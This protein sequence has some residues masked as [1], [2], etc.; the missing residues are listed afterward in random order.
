MD[1]LTLVSNVALWV[2]SL[3]NLA[4][5]FVLARQIGVLHGRLPPVGAR[6]NPGGP[7]LGET[8]EPVAGAAI[9]GSVSPVVL[10]P[11]ERRQ[12]IVFITTD[13][14]AC[15]DLMPAVRSL[16]HS[17]SPTL[18]TTIVSLSGTIDDN[19]PFVKAHRLHRVRYVLAPEARSAYAIPVTPFAVLV[20]EHGS[21][22][23]K[24][25]VNRM[26]QLESLLEWEPHDMGEPHEH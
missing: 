4:A 13:C 3:V 2:L 26:E 14:S 19:R 7:P 18:T 8:L 10:P 16:A 23:S 24:A 15:A 1:G 22:V 5:V 20:D 21:V 6:G 25:L 9:D 17:D 12:L 11:T